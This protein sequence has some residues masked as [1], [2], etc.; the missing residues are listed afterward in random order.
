LLQ[1]YPLLLAAAA[2]Y[3]GLILVFRVPGQLPA[4]T[5]WVVAACAALIALIVWRR[6]DKV[7]PAVGYVLIL[8][9]LFVTAGYRA[10]TRIDASQAY[11]SPAEEGL[12]YFRAVVKD[13][14]GLEG[15]G[16]NRGIMRVE[17]A[18]TGGQWKAVGADV[19]LTTQY[20]ML[21]PGDVLEGHFRTYRLKTDSYVDDVLIGQGIGTRAVA[22]PDVAITDSRWSFGR[23][24]FN[25]RLSLT[26][27]V[28]KA[29]EGG[30]LA[31]MILGEPGLISEELEVAGRKSAV[32]HLFIVSGMHLSLVGGLVMLLGKK[33]GLSLV[34]RN[35]LAV[36]VAFLYLLMTGSQAPAFRAWIMFAMLISAPLIR[37]DYDPVNSLSAAAL[38]LLVIR[39]EEALRH[40]FNLTMAA[41]VGIFASA[42]IAGPAILKLKNHAAVMVSQGVMASVGGSVGVMPFIAEYFG[43]SGGLSG[44][45][46]ALIGIPLSTGVIAVGGV[47]VIGTGIAGAAG[48]VTGWEWLEHAIDWVIG[49][50]GPLCYL[51]AGFSVLLEGFVK[52]L[53]QWTVVNPAVFGPPWWFT[54]LWFVYLTVLML[55]KRQHDTDVL[56]FGEQ[57]IKPF[58]KTRAVKFGMIPAAAA[59]L[60]IW[61]VYGELG[62]RMEPGTYV[63]KLQGYVGAVI[64]VN[65]DRMGQAY[66][67]REN[68]RAMEDVCT[69]F[70][71]VKMVIKGYFPDG[72]REARGVVKVADRK[73]VMAVEG[74][75][76]L[77]KAVKVLPEKGVAFTT[78]RLMYDAH[79]AKS[80]GRMVMT[81]PAGGLFVRED[82][83]GVTI[84]EAGLR[85]GWHDKADGLSFPYHVNLK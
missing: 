29:P 19:D 68:I 36:A 71:G 10:S 6:P 65:Q 70:P 79:V 27:R 80:S 40:G 24:I 56:L 53:A 83:E 59:L 82:A 13:V 76:S 72:M 84:M 7:R 50:S 77:E 4:L 67:E 20:L 75:D 11:L 26:R 34:R 41:I 49:V 73:V 23:M 66:L 14:D 28:E 30:F 69:A 48:A 3:A 31:G 85:V 9:L 64:R 2:W 45:I 74:E 62:K 12:H 18:R 57:V 33:A 32:L 55:L 63:A 1:S 46:G 52:L 47:V 81:V 22:G 5:P 78:S 44:I 38:F 8:A 16:R 25:A 58:Y 42:Y 35:L 21:A 39:P 61:P 51:A 17:E 37:R 15:S 60:L 43:R 54:T